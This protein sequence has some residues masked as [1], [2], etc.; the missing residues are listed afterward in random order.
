MTAALVAAVV[1][2][3][4]RSAVAQVQDTTAAPLSAADSIRADSIAADSARAAQTAQYLV[5]AD[6]ESTLMPLIPRL[7]EAAPGPAGSRLV[8]DRDSL[9]W[10]GAETVGDL[11]SRVPGLYLWRGGWLGRP[12]LPNYQGR[13]AGSVSYEIDGVPYLPIGPDSSAVDPALFSLSFLERVEVDRWPGLLRVRLYTTRQDRLAPHSRIGFAKGT[14]GMARYQAI[15]ERQFTSGFGY[16]LAADYL[17]APTLSGTS[18]DYRNTQIRA[19]GSWR[20]SPHAGVIVQSLSNHP[21]RE[22]FV[23]I[24]GDTLE[25]PEKGRRSDLTLRGYLQ[26]RNDGLGPRVDLIV[27]RSSW[28]GQGIS[29]RITQAGVV[30]AIRKPTLGLRLQGFYRSDRTPVDLRASLGW[31][32][33][34]I[35]AA[36]VEGGYQR[37]DGDRNSRWVA[38]RVGFQLPAGL[39]IGGSA[40][41]G[42]VV[43]TPALL[44]QSAQ[45]IT[46]LSAHAGFEFR[47]LGIDAAITRTSA[48]A[49][50]AFEPFNRITGIRPSPRTDWLTLSGHLSPLNWLALSA[51]Y[52]DPTSG[53]IDGLPPKHLLATAAIRSRFLRTFPSGTL[54]LKL[55]GTLENWSTGIIGTDA[56]GAPVVLPSATFFRT[57]IQLRLG[58]LVFYVDQ[59]NLS[60][61]IKSYVPGIAIPSLGNSIGFRWDFL[62]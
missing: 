42:K 10:S 43:S 62:N 19:Q 61:S 6:E 29:Q 57:L 21:R 2:L 5:A 1:V 24:G 17:N 16:A 56:T 11:L 15:L 47:R 54:E 27:S 39:R 52:A 50:A 8:F 7:G 12:E 22:A 32:P 37:H 36:D 38:G 28:E 60:R 26:R 14:S 31:T 13:G 3:S 53:P 58:N 48:F 49:P 40:R 18:S 59:I 23:G 33:A 41:V 44:D 51:A 20:I 34:G 25:L 4:A 45:S 30:G 46:D 35:L 55:Q 9:D